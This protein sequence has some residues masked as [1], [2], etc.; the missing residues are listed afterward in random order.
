MTRRSRS[1][2]RAPR[3]VVQVRD[4]R[5]SVIVPAARWAMLT[6][7]AKP[8]TGGAAGLR[9]HGI[10]VGTRF[11][12]RASSWPHPPESGR[13]ADVAIGAAIAVPAA[14]LKGQG[15]IQHDGSGSKVSPIEVHR[16]SSN[17]IWSGP[18]RYRFTPASPVNAGAGG[19]TA[20]PRARER[21]IRTSRA[22]E[23]DGWAGEVVAGMSRCSGGGAC[24]RRGAGPRLSACGPEESLPPGD[25]VLP[26]MWRGRR[27][28]GHDGDAEYVR[29]SPVPAADTRHAPHWLRRAGPCPVRMRFVSPAYK[30][31]RAGMTPQLRP[32]G[33]VRM[34]SLMRGDDRRATLQSR[35]YLW[36]WP[37]SSA[38]FAV[39]HE[40]HDQRHQP[41]PAHRRPGRPGLHHLV[42]AGDGRADHPVRQADRPLWPQRLFQLGLLVYGSA[43]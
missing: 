23:R 36:P 37:S 25:R 19:A 20:T 4:H 32:E 38:S 31:C 3:G 26:A 12:G 29:G 24:H 39:E 1:A 7:L 43:P 5:R 42:P 13:P 2:A 28:R 8:G 30:P 14:A 27:G 11:R 21:G 22:A 40:R 17:P 18:R 15:L 41:R 6:V 34:V 35:W 16:R 9:Q 10:K 33:Q